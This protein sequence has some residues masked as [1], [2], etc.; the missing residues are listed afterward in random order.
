VVG[1]IVG[2]FVASQKGLGYVIVTTQS[3]MNTSVAFAS[4]IWI[5]SSGSRSTAPSSSRRSV[6]AV[7]RGDRLNSGKASGKGKG[8]TS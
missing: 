8:K 5:P 1:A 4:L 6:G 3:S 2:E 7:G